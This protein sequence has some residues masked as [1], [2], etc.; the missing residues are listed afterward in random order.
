LVGPVGAFFG[1]R[2]G[3]L[4][5]RGLVVWRVLICDLDRRPTVGRPAL[6]QRGL[7]VSQPGWLAAGDRGRAKTHPRAF[8]SHGEAGQRAT[9]DGDLSD[10]LDI[11]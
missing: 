5:D 11:L 9:R 1:K 3:C 10:K 2:P 6:T 4:L 8:L 7:L